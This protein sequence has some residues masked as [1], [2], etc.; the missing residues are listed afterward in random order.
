[1]TAAVIAR[2]FF[3]RSNPLKLNALD[4]FTTFAMTTKHIPLRRGQGE[5]IPHCV[6]NDEPKPS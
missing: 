5:E 2:A 3:A 6:R 1:M 4:C